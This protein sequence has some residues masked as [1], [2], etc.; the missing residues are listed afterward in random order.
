MIPLLRLSADPGHLDLLDRVARHLD[1]GG[2]VAYP[3][4]TV[5]GLGARADADGV[6]GVRGLKGRDEEKPFL[7]LLP[8]EDEGGVEA[9]VEGDARAG[10]A[11]NPS[12]RA[13]ARAFWPGPLTL[14]LGDPRG[15]FPPGIRG[16]G[17]G[18]AIRRSPEPF[19][20]ALLRR[21]PHPLISTSANRPGEAPAR[22]A[23]QVIRAVEGRAGLD[24]LWI[25]DGGPRVE[26]APSTVLDC[27]REPPRIIRAGQVSLEALRKAIPEVEEA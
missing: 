16:P 20:E 14:V 2:L 3:T 23:D 5:Y 12:A 26:R 22:D 9:G 27:T 4:E 1:G 21:W 19:V 13:L 7:M 8:G 10:L 18:V 25:L 17:G 11:W 15:L 24:R 6:E